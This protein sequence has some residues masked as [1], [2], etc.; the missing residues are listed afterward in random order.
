MK[1]ILL[2]TGCVVP[3]CVDNL[4]VRD[5]EIRKGMYIDSIKWYLS[6]TPYDI[7][8]CENSGTDLSSYLP[9]DDRL[10]FLTF[11][12]PDNSSEAQSR[13]SRELAIIKY[14]YENSAKIAPGNLFVKITGRLK[15]LNIVETANKILPPPFNILIKSLLVVRFLGRK[16]TRIRGASFLH[17]RSLRECWTCSQSLATNFLLSEC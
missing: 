12:A 4:C 1:T 2:L 7:V 14:A 13:S 15:Y 9:K 6:N 10:E 8:F 11:T 17:T 16:F 5:A 3:N